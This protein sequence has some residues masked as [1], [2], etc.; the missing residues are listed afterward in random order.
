M[1]IA[2]LTL[3]IGSHYKISILDNILQVFSSSKNDQYGMIVFIISSIAFSSRPIVLESD[4]ISDI[5]YVVTS[6]STIPLLDFKRFTINYFLHF[7]NI[8]SNFFIVY[9]IIWF[10]NDSFNLCVFDRSLFLSKSRKD[11]INK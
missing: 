11:L 2:T 3:V 10:I 7:K 1:D 8:M 9:D 6:C 4:Y 5:I